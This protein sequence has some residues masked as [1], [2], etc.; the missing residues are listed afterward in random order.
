[1]QVVKEVI[2]KATHLVTDYV[3]MDDTVGINLETINTV[4]T[5][6]C[7]E[8]AAIPIK[9]NPVPLES[10]AN[11]ITFTSH[12][13]YENDT[14]KAN[15]VS[16][17]SGGTP[18]TQSVTIEDEKFATDMIETCLINKKD[19]KSIDC[20]N[21]A[22]LN[23]IEQVKSNALSNDLMVKTEEWLYKIFVYSSNM[24]LLGVA[25]RFI[26]GSINMVGEYVGK[27]LKEHIGQ[28]VILHICVNENI[29]LEIKNS[30]LLECT[31]TSIGYLRLGANSTTVK[32]LQDNYEEYT[33]HMPNNLMLP[34]CN[35]QYSL[36]EI[37]D[38]LM[39]SNDPNVINEYF[40]KNK[41]DLFVK[42]NVNKYL[43]W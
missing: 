17:S 39:I 42:I 9:Y 19:I 35:T 5:K 40:K 36:S 2:N 3:Y 43:I 24:E 34:K 38:K 23:Y 13:Q 28:E 25:N 30:E 21:N 33:I 8:V 27:K 4:N 29:T 20:Y 10:A 14:I 12:L 41:P 16:Q 22:F 1:M 15:I 32:R 18:T 26:F 37:Y 6:K 11:K 7:L 31:D